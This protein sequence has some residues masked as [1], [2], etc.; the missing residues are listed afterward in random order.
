[1]A[2]EFSVDS[3]FFV[4]TR[5][6]S[7][8]KK[9]NIVVM[10]KNYISRPF[11]IVVGSARFRTSVARTFH[12][13]IGSQ[14]GNTTTTSTAINSMSAPASNIPND[15]EPDE[16]PYHPGSIIYDALKLSDTQ[17]LSEEDFKR[18]IKFLF[19]WINELMMLIRHRELLPQILSLN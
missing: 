19:S 3:N 11:R 13:Q 2:T 4:I 5:T 7:T 10:K 17:N 8:D 6:I 1:M 12:S 9:L 15:G 16:E 14:N 18:I